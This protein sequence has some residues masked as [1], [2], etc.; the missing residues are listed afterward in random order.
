M[1]SI[2]FN[3]FI[4]KNKNFNDYMSDHN[5]IVPNICYIT[6][7][8]I[9]MLAGPQKIESVIRVFFILIH[10]VLHQLPVYLKVKRFS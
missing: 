10:V 1:S 4:A 2:N 6:F 3:L 9:S 8:I 5:I 7:S